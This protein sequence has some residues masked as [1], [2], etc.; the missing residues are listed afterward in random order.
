MFIH[1]TA[2]RGEVGMI[3]FLACQRDILQ[4]ADL[5]AKGTH[6]HRGSGSSL[7]DIYKIKIQKT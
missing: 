3:A 4:L 7:S 1:S 5:L 6:A 2:L